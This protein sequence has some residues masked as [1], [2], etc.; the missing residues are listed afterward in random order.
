[1]NLTPE[2]MERYCRQVILPGV[3]P[4]G[5]RKLLSSSVL[6]IGTGGLGSAI[7]SYLAA[8]AVGRIG[9][10]D[11]D[12]V[13]LSNLHRQIV[14]STENIGRPKVES[15]RDR[16]LALNPDV[17]VETYADR[18]T[19]TNAL[20]LVS[21]YDAVLD[22]SDNFPTRFLANDACFFSRRPLFFGAVLS[23]EGTTSVF[24]PGQPDE[25]CY[26]CLFSE[27]PPPGLVPT[28]AEVGILGAV[29][30]LIGTIQA[31]DCIKYLLGIGNNLNRRLLMYDALSMSVRV[32]EIHKNR[33]CPLC[34]DN[35]TI[36]SLVEYDDRGQAMES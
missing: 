31:T 34:G 12:R 4:S 1:M 28:S 36:T 7:L 17:K 16:I 24:F 26:R 23:Y 10:I 30:G 35:P 15:A 27:P 3:G 19:K 21:Q 18:F 2:Q 9:V 20:D 14:H 11:S 13:E 25:P 33:N 6:C 5:Q 29:A 22:G 8:A 32:V